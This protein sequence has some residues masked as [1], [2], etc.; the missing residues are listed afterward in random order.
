MNDTHY[1]LCIHASAQELPDLGTW[2]LCTM[3]H[4]QKSAVFKIVRP[5]FL[6]CVLNSK[7]KLMVTW[8]WNSIYLDWLPLSFSSNEDA[9]MTQQTFCK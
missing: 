6:F 8:G 1:P 5:I 2:T 4:S 9:C 7:K 3:C